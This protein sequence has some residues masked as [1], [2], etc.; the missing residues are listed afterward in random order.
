MEAGPR[1]WPLV[2]S[3]W[4]TGDRLEVTLTGGSSDKDSDE[5]G[6]GVSAVDMT[7]NPLS[8]SAQLTGPPRAARS[9]TVQLGLELTNLVDTALDMSARLVLPLGCSPGGEWQKKGP[10]A[11][12]A[13][14][15]TFKTCFGISLGDELNLEA[16][17]YAA[18]TSM[19]LTVEVFVGHTS[20]WLTHAIKIEP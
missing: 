1:Q 5:Y 15:K 19:P 9:D 8:F 2:W 18:F 20:F 10:A 7:S 3:D 12:V 17:R 13:A 4:I 6:P 16:L 11:T 14:G